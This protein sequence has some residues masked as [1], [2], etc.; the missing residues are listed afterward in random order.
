MALAVGV[1]GGGGQVFSADEGQPAGV[2]NHGVLSGKIVDASGSPVPNVQ[3]DLFRYTRIHS[4]KWAR[5]VHCS[6]SLSD[7]DGRY[8]FVQLPAA[9]YAI[10]AQAAGFARAFGG[11]GVES[12]GQARVDVVLGP[13]VAPVIEIKDEQGRPVAGAWVREFRQRGVNGEMRFP[14]MMV[15][16]LGIAIAKSDETGR[17]Q[18]PPLPEGDVLFRIVVEHPNLAPVRIDELTIVP[19]ATARATMRPGV[20]L[21]LRAVGDKP[22]DRVRRVALDLRPAEGDG[23][24]QSVYREIEFDDSGVAR[25]AIEPG[26]YNQLQLEHDDYYFTPSSETPL[27][28]VNF[29]KEQ[30]ICIA[31]GQNDDLQFDVLPKVMARG[32]VVD[33]ESARPL[34][35]LEILGEIAAG[36]SRGPVVPAVETWA[37][38]SI[39]RTNKEGKFTIPLAAGRAR[40]QFLGGGSGAGGISETDYVEFAAAADNSTVI[41]D[42]RVRP[43]PRIVGTVRNPDGGPAARA[44]VCLRGSQCSLQPVLTDE[45]GHFELQPH[46]L[47]VDEATGEHLYTQHLWAFDPYRSLSVRAEVRLDQPGKP[48]LKLE[49]H[50]PDWVLATAADEMGSW[51]RGIVPPEVAEEN[52]AASLKGRQPPELDGVAW[53]NTDGKPLK[54]ADLRGKYVLL[55]FWFTGCGPCHHDFPSVKLVH[56]LYN[57]KGVVVIGVHTNSYGT[58]DEVRK[59]VVDIALPFPVVV[60]HADGRMVASFRAHGIANG[61]PNYVLI[62]PDGTILLDDRTI[63]H[64]PLHGYKVEIVRQ[65]LLSG[66]T[67][68]PATGRQ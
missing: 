31:K 28:P 40:V 41:P 68:A 58:L 50:E 3:V 53:L 66:A 1:F 55:D 47:P 29:E 15:D 60:D 11:N 14:Q 35:G 52:A 19:G 63:P 59:H 45:T 7:K 22:A 2:E 43:I 18:L 51:A 12:G 44:V 65:Y 57:D 39:E 16:S 62:G 21:T 25:V 30:W 54:L 4:K 23:P 36:A 61:F 64:P 10:S 34:P 27:P 6:S 56:E 46:W 48:V 26:N 49:P 9:D 13:P 24:S 33:A 32:R 38:A 20:V 67:A 37:R 17:I 8:S 5:W 42:I